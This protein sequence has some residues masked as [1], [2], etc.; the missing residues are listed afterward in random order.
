MLFRSP[1]TRVYIDASDEYDKVRII[2]KNISAYEMKLSS[3]EIF[4]VFKMGDKSR[5]TEGSGFGLAI[6]KSIVELEGGRMDI[7]IDGD[8]FKVIIIFYK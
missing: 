1:N 4:E 7:E 8:L 5:N 6:A 3:E 2:M